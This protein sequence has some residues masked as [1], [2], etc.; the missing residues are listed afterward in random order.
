VLVPAVV[1][2]SVAFM[3]LKST[4]SAS[5]FRMASGL[6][7]SAGIDPDQ[8]K[9]NREPPRS[10]SSTTFSALIW[11]ATCALVCDVL[12]LATRALT[13]E[14]PLKALFAICIVGFGDLLFEILLVVALL[15]GLG[16][17]SGGRVIAES[18]ETASVQLKLDDVTLHY[19]GGNPGRITFLNCCAELLQSRTLLFPIHR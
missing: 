12:L 5:N 16:G 11:L 2:A 15:N 1:F 19:D 18:A 13:I 10:R 8:R 14:V 4:Y 17:D 3:P 6:S 9:L 7:W